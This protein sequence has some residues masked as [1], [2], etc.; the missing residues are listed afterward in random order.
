MKFTIFSVAALVSFAGAAPSP[1]DP[2]RGQVGSSRADPDARLGMPSSYLGC[3]YAQINRIR[4]VLS[5]CAM[6]ANTA[7]QKAIEESST[8]YRAYFKYV[9]HS[10]F[11]Y[12]IIDATEDR[13]YL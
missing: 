2:F 7:S 11:M 1:A 12:L 8:K 4:E 13:G 9:Y 3:S 5:I 10:S 6:Q